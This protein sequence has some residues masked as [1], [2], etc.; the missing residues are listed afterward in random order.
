[1]AAVRV[2]FLTGRQYGCH[3]WWLNHLLTRR[4]QFIDSAPAESQ[5]IIPR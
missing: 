1:M 2:A 4:F 3:E 5:F